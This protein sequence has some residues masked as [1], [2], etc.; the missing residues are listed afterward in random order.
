MQ[1]SKYCDMHFSLNCPLCDET[2]APN[3]AVA[4]AFTPPIP[5]TTP[6]PT[7]AVGLPEGGTY[8]NASAIKIESG[9]QPPAIQSEEGQA[10]LNVSDDYARAC[11]SYKLAV[12]AVTD[13][14]AHL[15]K[16]DLILEELQRD[17]ITKKKH[18]D[19]LKKKVLETLAI[20]GDD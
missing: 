13:M 16:M 17:V 20:G 2:A 11:D 14:K 3:A 15:T 19:D 7:E 12:K 1:K 6:V 4:Q 5:F 18:K 8:I 10:V 9:P